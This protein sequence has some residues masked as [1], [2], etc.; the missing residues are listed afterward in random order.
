M[1]KPNDAHRLLLDDFLRKA[2]GVAGMLPADAKIDTP[3]TANILSMD[4]KEERGSARSTADGEIEPIR[5]MNAYLFQCGCAF[6]QE[7]IGPKTNEISA[8]PAIVERNAGSPFLKGSII[9]ADALNAQK[10]SVRCV[11]DREADCV[12]AVKGDQEI[13]FNNIKAS[14]SRELRQSILNAEFPGMPAEEDP[15]AQ[16]S[17]AESAAW[18]REYDK[19]RHS[20]KKLIEK[21]HGAT[22]SYKFYMTSDMSGIE[23][24][25]EWSGL[26]AALCE[27]KISIP[28]NRTKKMSV[29]FRYFMCS[30]TDINTASFAAR[31]HWSIENSL[32]WISDAVFGSDKCE[33]TRGHGAE[34]LQA[35]KK[36]AMAYLNYAKEAYGMGMTELRRLCELDYETIFDILGMFEKNNYRAPILAAGV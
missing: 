35:I 14:F 4:G 20:F 30:I 15:A 9:T 21:S 5:T 24:L 13:L 27:E 34:T 22:I 28:N 26:K 25:S 18:P 17:A 10:T 1:V 8:L 36:I 11:A 31:A 29:S 23:H 16:E 12:I 6:D 33:S 32:H 19:S 3:C 7:F 2:S